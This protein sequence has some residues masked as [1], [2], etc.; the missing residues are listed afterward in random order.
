MIMVY[1]LC[2]I[3][4]RTSRAVGTYQGTEATFRHQLMKYTSSWGI[5]SQRTRTGLDEDILIVPT[6]VGVVRELSQPC[7]GLCGDL[8][9]ERIND[10]RPRPCR[11]SVRNVQHLLALFFLY[12]AAVMHLR[13]HGGKMVRGCT[14]ESKGGETIGSFGRFMRL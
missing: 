12:G 2:L 4:S 8:V 14:V 7:D 11:H 6:P 5:E 13:Y 1:G 10:P 3:L 9:F